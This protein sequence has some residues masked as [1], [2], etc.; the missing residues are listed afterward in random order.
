MVVRGDR[1]FL[2]LHDGQTVQKEI[3]GYADYVRR[4]YAEDFGVC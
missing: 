3:A 4:L 1:A 2:F